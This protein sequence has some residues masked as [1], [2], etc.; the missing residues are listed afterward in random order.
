[1]T[2]N[3]PR[4]FSKRTQSGMALMIMLVIM[5]MGTSWAL[6]NAIS[7]ASRNT[8]SEQ[9]QT[10]ST[11]QL[12]K[13]VLLGYV[14]QQASTSDVPGMFPCPESTS[15]IGTSSEGEAS[16]TCI[17]LP[18]IGRLPWKTLGMDKPLDG[19]DTA[20]W[21]VVSADVRN[22]PINFS[23]TGSL[24]MDGT[25]NSAVAVIIA[26]GAALD[27]A[28]NSSSVPSPCVKRDQ[29]SGR[30][31]TP[32]NPSDFVECGNATMTALV[33]SRDDTWGNDR[34]VAITATEMHKAIEG[35]VGDRIQR[36]VAP[37]LNGT[38]AS[39]G[40]YQK[41]SSGEWGAQFFPYASTWTD[42]T[43]NGYCGS[44]GVTEGLLPIATGSV[45]AGT[46]CSARWVDNSPNCTVSV[47]SDP[48]ANYSFTSCAH[49]SNTGKMRARFRYRNALV[50]DI[51]L[52]ASNIAM[53]FRTAPTSSDVTFS[54]VVSTP[55]NAIPLTSSVT[56][57]T[58]PSIVTATGGGK[59]TFRVA[60]AK[61]SSNTNAS[62]WIPHPSDSYLINTS[63]TSNAD[64]AW[65]VNNEWNRYTYYAVSPALTVNPSGT[66][67]SADVTNCLTL[68]NAEAGTGNTNDK[69]IV[70]ILSGRP[71]SGQTSPLDTLGKFFES[72]NASSGDRTFKRDTISSTFNDRPSVCPYQQATGSATVLC[73]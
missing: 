39:T 29:S 59:L 71:L 32:L 68:T 56:S 45:T 14:A 9:K 15:S 49:D 17:T 24:T 35:A 19:S 55:S 25:A 63:T 3:G 48:G 42:P 52:N 38:E 18:A 27:T 34:A 2:R 4:A 58:Q 54:P 62:V 7:G 26:P 10:G 44:Y 51:T 47:V 67:T 36:K 31:S 64:L 33:S 69:R 70:L 43:T 60:M 22:A 53:G 20:L 8:V 11:L 28:S 16:S 65:F 21:Y 37:A 57:W 13:S 66:C 73:N 61:R 5:V 12:A 6:V 1:M 46:N 40:W 30:S 23:T 41:D 72:D 50:I